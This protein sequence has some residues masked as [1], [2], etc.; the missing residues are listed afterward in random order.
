M[1]HT[2]AIGPDT[3]LTRSEEVLEADIDGEKV[4]MSIERG[5]YYGLDNIG[6]EIWAMFEKPRAVSEVCA[7]MGARYNVSPEDCERDVVAF[8]GDLV[9]DGTLRLVEPP[10]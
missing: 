5:E 3:V 2:T 9:A 7:T 8:L 4:M 10:E 1:S 6:S